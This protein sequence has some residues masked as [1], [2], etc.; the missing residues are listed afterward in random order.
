MVNILPCSGAAYDAG[1][2]LRDSDFL[3][4]IPPH[5]IA[6]QIHQLVHPHTGA[7][8]EIIQFHRHPNRCSPEF[9]VREIPKEINGFRVVEVPWPDVD[10]S[11]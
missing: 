8:E 4:L 1:K 10:L 5:W 7:L 11:S 3:R 2:K 9:L 6:I